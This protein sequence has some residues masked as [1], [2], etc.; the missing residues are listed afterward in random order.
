MRKI[1]PVLLLPVVVAALAVLILQGCSKRDDEGPQGGSNG[2]GKLTI[3]VI[4]KGVTHIFWKS[5]HDGALAAGAEFGYRIQW[6]GP[7]RETDRDEQIQ[8]VEDV[9]QQKVAAVVLAPLDSKA[10][11]PSVEKLAELGIPCA[12][13]DSGIETGPE[14]YVSF[15]ATENYDGGVMAARRMGKILNG[16]GNVV[17]LRYVR[18]SAST[19]N[20]EKGFIETIEKEFPG[21]KV[22]DDEYGED[23]V[24]TALRVAEDLLTGNQNL[25]GFFACNEPTSLASLQAVKSQG[26]TEVKLVG[27]DAQQALIDAVNSGEIDSLVVQNPYKIGYEGVKAVVEHMRGK[28][29]PK[30]IFTGIKLITKESL[31]APDVK[32]LLK[33]HKL[34]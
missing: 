30:R 10:L 18:G 7:V 13:I 21:I 25:Q 4:P 11:A 34:Q 12:I 6:I 8:I 15:A 16:K 1:L 9:I 26:R 32:E 3:G 29:V 33:L 5:V 19:T 14:N 17:V 28:K 2:D 20:R 31:K 23:T 27:F 22:V 24:E